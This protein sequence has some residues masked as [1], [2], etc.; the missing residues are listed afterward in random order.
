MSHDHTAMTT[1]D[2]LDALQ[3]R[4]DA[5][6]VE[7]M[8]NTALVDSYGQRFVYLTATVKALASSPALAMPNATFARDLQAFKDEATR[9]ANAEAEKTLQGER[10]AAYAR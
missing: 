2:A 8:R 10:K 1:A 7:L 5:Q 6:K 9:S 4:F 3:G